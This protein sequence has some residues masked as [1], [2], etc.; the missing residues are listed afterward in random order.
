M[1]DISNAAAATQ[2]QEPVVVE[3]TYPASMRELWDLWTTKDG[4]ESWWGPEGFRVEVNA[5]EA[6]PDGLLDYDMIADAP[7]AIAAMERMGQPLSHGT[8]GRFA[9]FRPFE[10]LSLVHV[11]DFI[12]GMDPYESR[13]DVDFEPLGDRTRMVVTLHPHRD[14]HWSRMSAEGFGSQMGKLDRRF[15]TAA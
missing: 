11:I 3:R 7:E 14:P 10:R 12:A 2:A 15:G 4:F 1:N 9:E 5:L 6:R 8:R 13:I